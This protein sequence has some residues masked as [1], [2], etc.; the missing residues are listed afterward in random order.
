MKS[1]FTKNKFLGELFDN[2]S[3][4]NYNPGHNTLRYFYI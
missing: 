4:Q 2:F 1:I 3:S